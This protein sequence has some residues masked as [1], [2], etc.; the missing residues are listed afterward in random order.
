MAAM[1]RVRATNMSVVE[2]N[3]LV[4]IALRYENTIENKRT[5]GVSVVEKATAWASI[6]TDFNA[7]S[8]VKREASSLKQVCYRR[9]YVSRRSSSC[10]SSHAIN[11]NSNSNLM[12]YVTNA[13]NIKALPEKFTTLNNINGRRYSCSC[14]LRV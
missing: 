13:H 9:L 8:V 12:E 11:S 6:A 1:K 7:V 5:D 3:M 14:Y 4:D 10:L 2:K